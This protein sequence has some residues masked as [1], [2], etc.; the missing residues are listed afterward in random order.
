MSKLSAFLAGE[1]LDDVAIF[2]TAEYLDEQ[3][4]LPTVGETVENGY[5]LVVPGDD[6]RRAFAAGTGMDAMEFAQ[7]AMDN[8]GRIDPT[9]GDGDC[10]NRAPDENHQVEF[11]F[12]FAEAQNEGVGGIYGEGDVV[13]A[14][15]HCTCGT[16]YSDRWVVGDRAIPPREAD[17]EADA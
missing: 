5:V 12:A 7:M 8:D 17:D 13:H 16:N 4:K 14:Y 11:V 15:A 1:R 2:L 9:L 10:P 3:G 6:G